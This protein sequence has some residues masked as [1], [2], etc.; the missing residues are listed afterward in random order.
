MKPPMKPPLGT[1]AGNNRQ[2][3]AMLNEQQHHF[4][5]VM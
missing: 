5:N 2:S 1:N 3:I 4:G